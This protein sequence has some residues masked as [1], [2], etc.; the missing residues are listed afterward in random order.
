VNTIGAHWAEADVEARKLLVE[1]GSAAYIHPFDHPDI[2][3]GNA[4]LIEEAAQQ[5]DGNVPGAVVCV[6]GGTPP[7]SLSLAHSH[8]ARRRGVVVWCCKGHGEGG[9]GQRT[10]PRC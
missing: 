10:H 8:Y 5:M 4:T 3:D 7:P 6:V 2:W 1:K 9:M